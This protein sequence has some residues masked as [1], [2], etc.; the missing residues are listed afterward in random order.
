MV[1]DGG[2]DFFRAPVPAP[3]ASPVPAATASSPAAVLASPPQIVPA[4]FVASAPPAPFA[5]SAPAPFAASAPAPSPNVSAS[6]TDPNDQVEMELARKLV[7]PVRR[8]R[9]EY[10]ANARTRAHHDNDFKI[11]Q[12]VNRA[13]EICLTL[14]GG[15]TLASVMELLKSSSLLRK[16]KFGAIKAIVSVAFVEG[17]GNTSLVVGSLTPS[18]TPQVAYERASVVINPHQP[19][20]EL[21]GRFY[22]C[23]EVGAVRYVLMDDELE[24]LYPTLMG[25]PVFLP[26]ESRETLC[27]TVFLRDF[28][29]A[30]SFRDFYGAELLRDLQF[31]FI[32]NLQTKDDLRKYF[33]EKTLTI[34]QQHINVLWKFYRHYRQFFWQPVN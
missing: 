8:K 34:P 3:A 16:S 28:L 30:F 27:Y 26:F 13:S 22:P 9:R 31:G 24:H 4:P 29:D 7:E 12:S 17:Y 21:F 32:L 33:V 5:A 23:L 25:K 2:V 20:A 11:N 19:I 15:G 18:Y 10:L 1:S 6:R 14:N